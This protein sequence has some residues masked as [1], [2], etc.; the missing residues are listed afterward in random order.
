MDRPDNLRNEALAVS[1]LLTAQRE[2]ERLEPEDEEIIIDSESNLTEMLERYVAANILDEA[3]VHGL[4]GA[5]KNFQAR[6]DRK[7]ARIER[8]RGAILAA[9][10]IVGLTKK[11]LATATL[12][13]SAGRPKVIITDETALPNSLFRKRMIHEPDITA[14]AEALK[15]GEDVPGAILSNTKPALRVLLK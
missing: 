11:E 10:E 15:A 3:H 2:L 1:I 12:S 5:I 4:A 7:A 14:I 6:S 9:L 8:R 13:V